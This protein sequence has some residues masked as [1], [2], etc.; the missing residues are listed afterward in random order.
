VAIGSVRQCFAAHGRPQAAQLGFPRDG[1]LHTG[2]EIAAKLNLGTAADLNSFETV[3]AAIK[4]NLGTKIASKVA[5]DLS[6]DKWIQ[7]AGLP[8]EAK[9]YL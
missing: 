9:E 4:Q 8:D 5:N 2:D 1:R 3:F 6:N 7:N